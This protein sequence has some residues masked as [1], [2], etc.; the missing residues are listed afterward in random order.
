MLLI[1]AL[2]T[3]LV[4]GSALLAQVERRAV[5]NAMN[6]ELA[7][8]NAFLALDSA[9]NQ[10]QREAGPDQRITA[11]ADVLDTS[12][13]SLVIQGVNNPY[14]SG[15]W[16]I[17]ANEPNKV[18]SSGNASQRAQTFGSL[19]PGAA[20]KATTATWL[21][22]TPDPGTPFDP[23]TWSGGIDGSGWNAVPLA[24]DYGAPGR[25]IN[26]P[27]VDIRRPRKTDPTNT[28]LVGAYAYWVGDEGVKAKVNL[29]P[30]AASSATS[31]S[32]QTFNQQHWLSP[33][34]VAVE[35]ALPAGF[36]SFSAGLVEADKLSG[37]RAWRRSRARWATPS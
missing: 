19:S 4:V 10:L 5:G 36:D 33:A 30:S 26:S 35:K 8:Q 28:D 23:R 15:I 34:T 11:R 3:I 22:S 18:L 29:I 1:I 7:R 21:I 27:L 32:N 12:P 24:R 25:D 9:F 6:A 37:R 31:G 17:G 14:W 13:N 2:V 20:E 16:R